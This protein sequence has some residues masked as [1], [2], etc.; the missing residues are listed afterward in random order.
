[1]T[2]DE[3]QLTSTIEQLA[4][5]ALAVLSQ[6]ELDGVDQFHVGGP[7]AVERLLGGLSL[8]SAATAL[9]VGSGFGGPARQIARATGCRVVG[10]DITPA[11]VEAATELTRNAG[12]SERVRFVA[13]SVA[14]LPRSD[15]HGVDGFGGFDGFD[16][17]D[18]AFT[19]HVQMNVADKQG[20][21]TDIARR[22]RPGARLAVFEVCRGGADPVLPLPLPWTLDGSD[23]FLATP[24]EL[25]EAIRTSGFEVVEWVDDSAWAKDWFTEL[26]SRLAAAGPRP[27]SLPALLAD[28]PARLLNFAVA[29]S[30]GTVTVHRGTFALPDA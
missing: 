3:T 13:S 29:L 20:F 16:G 17:F 22:L 10:V 25:R 18:A 21:Y 7:E 4:G 8:G 28:G 23:S 6:D 27:L 19:I 1:M 2:Y 14:E 30:E 9:D 11:Y 26:G 24:G 15:A 5:K 12:L